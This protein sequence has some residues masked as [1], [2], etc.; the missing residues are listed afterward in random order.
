M[1]VAVR[2]YKP[3]VITFWSNK[4]T[5]VD[6]LNEDLKN[7]PWHIG[8]IFDSADDH[9]KYWKMLFEKVLQEHIPVKRKRVRE[10]DIPYMNL[11]WKKAIRMTSKYAQIY[12]KHRT[13][14][15]WD[16]KRK[17]RN[18]ATRERRKEIKAYWRKLS[19][20]RKQN[21]KEFFQVFRPFLTNKDK[22]NVNINIDINGTIETDQIKITARR[23][24][25]LFLDY[26][27]G[28]RKK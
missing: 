8:E 16:M 22:V 26:S 13:P 6:R 3:K 5:N 10:R 11:E 19:D 2:R 14:E 23:I 4:N 25:K 28:C 20:N 12:S 15:N 17:W 27:Y 1:S 21:R 7:A 18:I 24:G 9:N